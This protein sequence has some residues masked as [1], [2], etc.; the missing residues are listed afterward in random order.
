VFKKGQRVRVPGPDRAN[1]ETVEAIYVAPS[2]PSARRAEWVWVRYL[3]GRE[4]GVNARVRYADVQACVVE[5][6]ERAG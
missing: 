1:G 2:E 5:P 6:A 3:D 4:A